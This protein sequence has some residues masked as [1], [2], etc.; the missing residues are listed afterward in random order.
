MQIVLFDVLRKDGD[1]DDEWTVL[2]ES[3][4]LDAYSDRQEQEMGVALEYLK[5]FRQDIANEL[6][7]TIA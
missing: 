7:S 1:V 6:E 5:R 3:E 4:K 2:Q